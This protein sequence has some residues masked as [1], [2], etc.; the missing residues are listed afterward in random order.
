MSNWVNK[1]M[2][3]PFKKFPISNN[4]ISPGSLVQVC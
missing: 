1:L 3:V 2:G 4:R